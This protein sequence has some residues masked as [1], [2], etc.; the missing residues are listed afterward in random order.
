M[1]QNTALN[2]L[3]SGK[4][5]F[6]TGQ[7]G[8]GKTY[9][10][11]KYIQYLR[12][13]GVRIAVTA[14]TGIAATHIGGVTI[15]SRSWIGIKDNLTDHD[16]DLIAQKEPVYKNI[17][18]A[19]VLIIDEISMLSA[20][21][22]DNVDRVCKSIRRDRR[23]FGGLQVVLCGDFFQ[24]PP[25]FRQA[26]PVVQM[27]TLFAELNKWV[28][29]KRFA[30]AAQSRKEADFA[31]CYLDTQHRQQDEKF[32][33]VLN[34]LRIGQVSTESIDLLEQRKNQ[35]IEHAWLTRLF[36]HNA[37][38]DRINTEELDKLSEQEHLFM[39][40][41]SGDKRLIEVLKKWMLA[42]EQLVLKK[43]AQVLFL[44]N[45]PTKWYY[46]GT[47]WVVKNFDPLD[48][49]PRVETKDG[50]MIKVEPEA[51]AIDNG[52][53]AMAE[54][55]QIPLKLAWAI[56]V[57]KSQGMTL[58][59]A[60]IDLSRVFEPGQ[61]Y[62]ALSRL[63]TLEG[64]H[65]LWLNREGLYAHPLVVRADAYFQT[66][67]ALYSADYEWFTDDELQLLHDA[68]MKLIGGSL[69]SDDDGRTTPS[70]KASSL[71]P[72]KKVAFDTYTKTLELIKQW[73]SVTDIAAT[74]ELA[75]STIT[76]HV[77]K[78]MPIHPDVDFS[79]LKPSEQIMKKL[80]DAISTLDDNPNN[81]NEDGTWKSKSIFEALWGVLWYPEIK[82]WLLFMK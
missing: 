52:N 62:V 24:L 79:Y 34:E 35:I 37:D 77:I 60:Q 55:R 57:H 64:L 22:L 38:V 33:K 51:R 5:V 58:D 53:D 47:T 6:L 43:W 74:R 46:N 59:V 13:Y 78:L 49:M 68:F 15:H 44:K 29:K 11:N 3:K 27:D 41:A 63:R 72:A 70:P 80:Q 12:D 75:I 30:F 14:S 20:N 71:K 39:C 31:I 19:K 18:K 25:V 45:N 9:V 36:T 65:L 54:V 21:M 23:P 26:E 17:S 81:L 82:F 8:S 42:M 61:A 66:Q 56:T 73:L 16:I 1:N 50:V 48:R 32:W 4:N 40:K 67:S 69:V 76:D 2:I 10:L 28:D 7:A